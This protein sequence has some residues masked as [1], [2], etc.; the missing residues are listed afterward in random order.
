MIILGKDSPLNDRRLILPALVSHD[1]GFHH[2]FLPDFRKGSSK[3]MRSANFT[4]LLG[5]EILT[6]VEN[7][8]NV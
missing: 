1:P 8:W 6:R 4:Y 3:L 7:L 5:G 2:H